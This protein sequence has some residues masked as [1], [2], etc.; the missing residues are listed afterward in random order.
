MEIGKE[1]GFGVMDLNEIGLVVL[2]IMIE[3]F[4]NLKCKEKLN[5]VDFKDEGLIIIKNMEKE[6]IG[7]ELKEKIFFVIEY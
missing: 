3:D 2:V 6:N 1:E 5:D 4:S 7:Y